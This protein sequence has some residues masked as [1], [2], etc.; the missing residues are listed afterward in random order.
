M[1]VVPR[2]AE[3]GNLVCIILGTESPY[4]LRKDPRRDQDDENDETFLLVGECYVHGIMDRE[5]MTGETR[6]EEF[7]LR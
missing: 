6:V 3:E 1:A 5:L 4:V 2:G 7:I